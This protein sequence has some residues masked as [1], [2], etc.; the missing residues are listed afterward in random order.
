[1]LRGR[2]FLK[3]ECILVPQSASNRGALEALGLNAVRDGRKS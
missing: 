2:D 3:G 1:M